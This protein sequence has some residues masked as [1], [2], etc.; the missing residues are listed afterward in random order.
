MS[1]ALLIG[2]RGFRRR[3]LGVARGRLRIGQAELA[4]LRCLLRQLL[5]DCVP[6]RDPTALGTRHRTLDQDEAALDIVDPTPQTVDAL[7][8]LDLAAGVDVEIKL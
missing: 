6:Q 4:R 3:R 5:L 7:M 8:K 1:R 2:R